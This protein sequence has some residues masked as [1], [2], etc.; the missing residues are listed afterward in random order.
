M[1]SFLLFLGLTPHAR[2][3]REPATKRAFVF[4]G[5]LCLAIPT[6]RSGGRRTTS[7]SREPRGAGLSGC[8]R[9]S[10]GLI[11]GAK[12]YTGAGSERLA[13]VC[14]GTPI[15]GHMPPGMSGRGIRYRT[16]GLAVPCA[17]SGMPKEKGNRFTRQNLLRPRLSG[18]SLTSRGSLK[19]LAIG[20]TAQLG[21]S[22]RAGRDSD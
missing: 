15:L 13:S 10:L 16:A 17:V 14:K 2:T 22:S 8:L 20:R 9:L 4:Y 18:K 5:V 11:G 12:T 21:N 1:S 6:D 19:T 3:K 7:K